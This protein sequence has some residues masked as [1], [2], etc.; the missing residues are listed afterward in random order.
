MLRYL[1]FFDEKEA[2]PMPY[3][4]NPAMNKRM[5]NMRKALKLTQQQVAD[6]LGMTNSNI[7]H[8]ERNA[9]ITKQTVLHI[10][11][12]WNVNYDYLVY[13]EGPM[14]NETADSQRKFVDAYSQL[15]PVFQELVRDIIKD[16]QKAQTTQSSISSPTEE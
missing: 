12:R 8:M 16:I 6:S 11:C 2:T 5:R 15:A 13:G 9:P 1:I 4:Y 14:F 7:S 3:E 10:C